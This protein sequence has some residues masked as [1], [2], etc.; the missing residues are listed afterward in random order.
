LAGWRPNWKAAA[1]FVLA[2]AA[3]C[4]PWFIKNW[5]LT[6]NPTYPLLYEVFGGASR[7]DANNSQWLS[8]HLPHGFSLRDLAANLSQVAW[9][10]DWISPI[11]V[12]LAILAC[13]APGRRRTVAL[14]LFAFFAY[15]VAAWWLCTH[16]IDRFWI[17]ALPVVALLAGFG[18]TWSASVA[19]RRVLLATLVC[20]LAVNWLFVISGPGGYNAYFARLEQLRYDTARADAWHVYL[21]RKVPPGYKVLTVGDARVFDLEMPVLY[22]TVF[23]DS[24][25]ES[26]YNDQH[27]DAEKIHFELVRR[28]ISHVYVHWSEIRRYRSPGNYGFPLRIKHRLFEELV[29]AGVFE[30]PLESPFDEREVYPVKKL[31]LFK[32]PT[33]EAA[34]QTALPEGI[35]L[36]V[37]LGH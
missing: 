8:A 16:R 4:A 28:R 23:D 25:F 15:V 22:N 20:G 36:P 13:L 26:I 37:K 33:K 9:R 30:P 32:V 2:C 24:V 34:G 3:G 11:L 6:G 21:N 19:W 35:V 29:A 7:T 18:A 10:S 27:G 1:F 12:P 14:A 5:A 31:E 17:P